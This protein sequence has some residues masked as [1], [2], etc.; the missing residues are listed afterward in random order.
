MFWWLSGLIRSAW[1]GQY[2]ELGGHAII[3]LNRFKKK[4]C[5]RERD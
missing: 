4:K 5:E 3:D 2:L 1:G